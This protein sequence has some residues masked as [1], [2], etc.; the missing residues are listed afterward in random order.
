MIINIFQNIYCKYRYILEKKQKQC[1]QI[2][3]IANPRTQP[4]LLLSLEPIYS[5]WGEHYNP[6]SYTTPNS[7]SLYTHTQQ[8]FKTQN[9][10]WDATRQARDLNLFCYGFQ[11]RLCPLGNCRALHLGSF[12]YLLT[13]FFP[14]FLS[15][16]ESWKNHSIL[17]LGL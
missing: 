3:I 15:L 13:P 2:L 7:L 12:T 1:K 6:P 5:C 11:L 8:P 14:F 10:N 17:M 4:Q 16:A 9:K